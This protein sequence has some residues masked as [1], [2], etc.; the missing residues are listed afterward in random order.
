MQLWTVLPIAN[1]FGK[2]LLNNPR[3]FEGL[4]KVFWTVEIVYS[5]D[6]FS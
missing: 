5:F 6:G 1:S 3:I 4:E 2:Y